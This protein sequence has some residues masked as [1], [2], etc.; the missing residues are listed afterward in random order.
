MSD[1]AQQLFNKIIKSEPMVDVAF[2]KAVR[3]KLND[4]LE[5]RKISLTSDIYNNVEK[6]ETQEWT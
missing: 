6:G 4:A 1:I 3:E 2:G 5:I